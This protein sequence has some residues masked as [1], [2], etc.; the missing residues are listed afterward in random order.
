M[1]KRG[2]LLITVL[3]SLGLGLGLIAAAAAFGLL[4]TRPSP[5]PDVT[6]SLPDST[7]TLR[8]SPAAASNAP[9]D[10]SAEIRAA[11]AE[12]ESQ[13]VL[14][15]GLEPIGPVER[16]LLTPEELRQAVVN[17][18]LATY[19]REQADDDARMLNML[20]LLP[21][22]F[23]LW[24]LYADLYTEQLAGYYDPATHEMI[25]V[26]GQDFA[27]PQRLSYAHE[28]DH[29]LQD[30]RFGL[31]GAELRVN[32]EACRRESDRCAAVRS[33]LEG[34]A[35]LLETQWARTFA[36]ADDLRELGSFY[37]TFE[38]PAFLSAPRFLQQDFLFPYTYGLEFVR[39]VY[40]DG[41]WPAV[42]AV[43]AAPPQSSEQILHPSRYPE[44][45]PIVLQPPELLPALGPG[46]HEI[47]RGVMGEWTTRLVLAGQLT[48]EAAATAAEG[49]GGDFILAFYDPRNGGALVWLTQW[50][51]LRQAEE[52]F[53][54]FRDYGDTRFGDHTATATFTVQWSSADTFAVLERQS[55]QSLWIQAPGEAAAAA[56]RQAIEFPAP[57]P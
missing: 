6:P 35:T 43:Y 36:S 13:V 24:E 40:L 5:A 26:R 44:D 27:G 18:L 4:P 47:E 2:W 15:R 16:S 34:D 14:L 37:A 19:N 55:L 7:A 53:S 12:I 30:Q 32:D 11:L 57:V 21:L 50:D 42:N 49:W 56:L 45:V 46:W 17:D 3:S 38:S 28:Y 20:G 52:A 33:L 54:A 1:S 29:A 25:V 8:P 10:L 41:S 51:G 22:G 39:Q 9:D 48:P 23:D 31:M